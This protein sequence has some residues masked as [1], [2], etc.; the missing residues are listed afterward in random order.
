MF[1]S[2]YLALTIISACKTG[3]GQN[4]TSGLQHAA[5]CTV[6]KTMESLA[7]SCGN[8]R[9]E[10]D[11]SESAANCPRDCIDKN[12][13]I[14][15]V[16]AEA[17][18]CPSETTVHTPATPD[19]IASIVKKS[20]QNGRK[21]KVIGT[22]HASSDIQCTSAN[23]ETIVMEKFGK[24]MRIEKFQ[25]ADSVLVE[26]G[27]TMSEIAHFLEQKGYALPPRVPG[28]GSINIGGFVAVGAHGS[29]LKDSASISSSVLELELVVAD[30]TIKRF[31]KT[32]TSVDQWKAL[33]SSLGLLGIM[34]KIRLEIRKS[35][36]MQME[37][38]EFPESIL[39]QGP[40]KF[41]KAL[42]GC[43][44]A[45]SHYVRLQ[46][47]FY[48]TCGWESKKPLTHPD[49]ENTLFKPHL[50]NVNIDLTATTNYLL[51]KAACN[52][53]SAEFL[54]KTIS[55]T[56]ARNPWIQYKGTDGK[57]QSLTEGVGLWHRM[58]TTLLEGNYRLTFSTMDW[59]VAVPKSQWLNASQ[60]MLN[61]I[62][63]H[64]I[65][66]P[67]IGVVSRFDRVN[68]DSLFAP[69][70]ADEHFALNEP[71]VLLE[72]PV[73][74]PF[75]L[76]AEQLEKYI[77]PYRTFFLSLIEKYQARPHIGKNDNSLLLSDVVKKRLSSSIKRFS[78]V[79]ATMD[80]KGIFNNQFAENMG[81]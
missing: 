66:L 37:I 26:T 39:S 54:E 58:M 17:H 34:T 5:D 25:D 29:N 33:R 1:L 75:G 2:V 41:Y 24:S 68:G 20:G 11:K 47:K 62:T 76:S 8:G 69:S 67:T 43:E 73:F 35:Y 52:E 71:L 16:Y 27:A 10:V 40:D 59:E 78:K 74:V 79:R 81:L 55:S 57:V 60:D 7:R 64:N 42:N 9:C 30:G 51:Q 65:I 6:P 4:D 63:K 49:L 21:I 53:S 38:R 14:A 22:R 3:G 46:K 70:A 44:F 77:L 28:V 45:F 48:V 61:F 56:R 13:R 36:H 50:A 18:I 15:S 31:D 23:G 72:M 19:E 80:P 32:N 12:K